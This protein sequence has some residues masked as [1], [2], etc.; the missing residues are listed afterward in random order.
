MKNI[1]YLIIC[2]SSFFSF[3]TFGQATITPNTW[4][5]QA[6]YLGWDINPG[7]PD[8]NIKH[9]LDKPIRFYTNAGNGIFNN[10]RLI[11]DRTPGHIGIGLNHMPGNDILDILPDAGIPEYRYWHKP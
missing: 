8:L 7:G 10:Q 9:E 11:I 3:K 1:T 2:I 4:F 5:S 6:D